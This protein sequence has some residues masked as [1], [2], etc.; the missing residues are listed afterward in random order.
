MC[1]IDRWILSKFKSDQKDLFLYQSDELAIKEAE[2]IQDKY[3]CYQGLLILICFLPQKY[4]FIYL[5]EAALLEEVYTNIDKPLGPTALD[6]LKYMH[7]N[8]EEPLEEESN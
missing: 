6:I 3:K 1:W 4:L 7:P 2:R 8:D 5:D